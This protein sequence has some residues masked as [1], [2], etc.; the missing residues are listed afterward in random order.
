M[1]KP[2]PCKNTSIWQNLPESSN[3]RV[4]HVPGYGKLRYWALLCLNLITG[5]RRGLYCGFE[6]QLNGIV[7]CLFFRIP[8]AFML[9]HIYLFQTCNKNPLFAL[10]HIWRLLSWLSLLLPWFGKAKRERINSFLHRVIICLLLPQLS[11]SSC[12]FLN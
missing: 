5:L 8:K 4:G 9:F 1:S 6:S 12:I 2:G 7:W 10:V 11:V 3:S